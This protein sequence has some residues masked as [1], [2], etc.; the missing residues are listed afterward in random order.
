[1]KKVMNLLLGL[2]ILL[3]LFG[4][5]NDDVETYTIT[6]ELNGGIGDSG[7]IEDFGTVITEPIPFKEGFTFGGWYLSEEY[8]TE[9]VFD[10]M[11]SKEITLYALWIS[12]D[13]S[14]TLSSNIIEITPSFVEGDI[15]NEKQT[16]TITAPEVEGNVFEYWRILDST[17]VVS[18][19][20]SFVYTPSSDVALEAVYDEI[21]GAGEPALYYETDFEDA[22]KAAYAEESITLSGESWNFVD[23][24]IGSLAT[25][26][27]VSGNSVRIR[28]GYI[29]TEFKVGN[30]AQVIFYAGTYGA[31]DSST[32]TFQISVNRYDWVIVDTFTS[33]S[34]LEE[35]NYVFDDAMFTSLSLNPDSEYYLKIASS[36]DQRA[37]IDGFQIYT[38]E[39]QLVDDTP[40]YI[41]TFTEDMEYSYLIDDIVDLTDCV[42]THPTNGETT[43]DVLGVVDSSVA[44]VYEIIFYKMDE[45]G[46]VV[47]VIVNI[48]IINDDT[49]DYLLMDLLAYYDDAEGLYGSSLMDALHDII[50][51][52]F[53]G[54][55]YGEVR[56]ILDE[57]DQDPNNINNLILVY[58]GTSI[59]STWDYGATWNREHVWPQSLLGVAADNAQVNMSSD[60]Y[61]IMP[62]N[63]GENSSRGN[64]P[65][66]EMGLGYEPRDEVKGD[67]ARALFYMMIMYEELNLV[68]TAPGVL[69][70]GYL[71]E[72]LQWHLEDPVDDFEMNRLDIIFSEQFNRN[73]FVDYP[74]FVELIWFGEQ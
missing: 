14:I 22:A 67:V 63:P 41:I 28:D 35:Y 36:T 53:V 3:S 42:A 57:T 29:E 40:L 44:E 58:L 8:T 69:E 47:F 65:Y 52:G 45:F 49:T 1:M 56:Y 66:S 54:V 48:T 72:L 34:T 6:L 74:H 70:M 64:S 7:I 2:V 59:N 5:K 43:C 20:L 39:G 30:L 61:N 10:T 27:S 46:N 19:E 11:P 62:A 9:Y 18:F 50:N 38:G 4:C 17:V 71:S 21:V 33:T 24:L 25:D 37:N 55:T 73:P 51:D 68:D 12:S 31:D 15:V 13:F 16:Y 23:A 32:V 26:L 60:L